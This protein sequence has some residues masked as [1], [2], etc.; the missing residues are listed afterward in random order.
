MGFLDKL[1]GAMQ[2]VTGGGAKVT[3]EYSQGLLQPGMPLHVRVT[4]TSTG[5]ELKSGGCF[6]DVAGVETVQLKD[7]MPSNYHG[8]QPAQ[9]VPVDVG[10]TADTFRQSFQIAGGFVLA[11]NETKVFE[12]QFVL[13]PGSQP[14]FQGKNSAHQWTV[15]GRV[16]AFGNDPDS[17]FLPFRVGLNA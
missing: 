14:T 10:T 17:G 7:V 9:H 1:K 13:P 6:L 15:R 12:G 4:A 5:R 16:E 2:A 3:I 11:P 8:A